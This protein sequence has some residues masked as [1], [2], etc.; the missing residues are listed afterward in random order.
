MAAWSQKE[1]IKTLSDNRPE[2]LAE[3][4]ETADQCR[5]KSIGDKVYLRGL[6]EFSNYCNCNCFYCGIRR[7]NRSVKRYRLKIDDVAAAARW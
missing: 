3:L 5:R 2:A 1:M 7:A 6:I 4:L